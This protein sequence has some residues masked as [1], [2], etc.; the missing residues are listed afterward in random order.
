MFAEDN[1]FCIL[2]YYPAVIISIN[3]FNTKTNFFKGF[4]DIAY[5]R[6]AINIPFSNTC[7]IN[8]FAHFIVFINDMVFFCW[9]S[10][11]QFTIFLNF[12]KII[13]VIY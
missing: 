10:N 7:L 12:Y 4:L 11:N 8:K 13:L 2:I 3:A 1:S 6:I 5:W 9:K